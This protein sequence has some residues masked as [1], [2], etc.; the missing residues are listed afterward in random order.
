MAI[1]SNFFNNIFINFNMSQLVIFIMNTCFC[2]IIFLMILFLTELI[3]E[4]RKINRIKGIKKEDKITA[5]MKDIR[6]FKK[7]VNHLELILKEKEKENNFNFIF[8]GTISL[9]IAS[10]ILLVTV[11]QL[12]L[13]I[14]SPVVILKVADEI[15]I[16]MATDVID[17]L[18]EQ[19]PNAID[20]IIRIFSKYGDIKSVIYESSRTCQQPIKGI[21]EDMSREMISNSPEK[22]LMQYAQKYDNVWF[23]S[24]VFVLISYLED[25]TKEETLLNLKN[26]RDI[27]EKENIVKK[28]SVTDKRYGVVVNYVICLFSIFGFVLNLIL[29]P[30]GKNF[31]FASFPGLI[32]FIFGIGSIIMTI[33]INI[34]MTKR[35]GK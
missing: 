6:F 33:F 23:Y 10:L 1:M 3:S 7:F 18:E 14:I 11:H 34:K 26:L 4:K 25:A 8:Y 2:L 29:N 27:L 9:A 35:S 20:N 12:L 32:C 22:I 15:C 13:A 31:F 21:L 19:L 5:K 30:V 17:N 16:R 28:A 24:L